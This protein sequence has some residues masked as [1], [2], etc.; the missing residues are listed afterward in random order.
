MSL[1]GFSNHTFSQFKFNKQRTNNC[2]TKYYIT[3]TTMRFIQP[4]LLLILFIVVLQQLTFVYTEDDTVTA[5]STSRPSYP[6]FPR[7]F[8]FGAGSS[9]VQVEGASTEDGKG[10]S[11]WDTFAKQAGRIADG[12]TLDVAADFYHKYEDDIRLMKNMGLKAYR[13]SLSWSRI[14]PN[15]TRSA[16]SVNHKAINHYIRIFRKLIDAGIEPYV[17]LYHWDLPQPLQDSFGGWLDKERISAAFADYADVCFFFFGRYVKNWMTINEPWATALVA[18][19]YGLY[20]PG[21]FSTTNYYT[22]S[23]NQLI[24]HAAAVKVYR[25][26]YFHQRGEIGIVF[27]SDWYEPLHADNAA[28]AAAAERYQL[29]NLGLY[30][31]PLYFGD[32]PQIVRDY[33]GS[34][35]P[36]FTAA[37]KELIRGSND[38]FAINHYTSRYV[39]AITS[40]PSECSPD[41]K[42]NADVQIAYCNG[43]NGTRI[44][45]QT[46]TVYNSVYPLG[47]R[48]LVKWISN[49]YGRNVDILIAEN[50]VDV[51]SESTLPLAQQLQDDFRVD[52]LKGYLAELANAINIDRI[53]VKGYLL[54]SFTDSW[55][56]IA[57]FVTKYGIHHVDFSSSAKTRTA[58][59]SANWYAGLIQSCQ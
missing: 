9:A 11:I 57:G 1:L 47:L 51:P 10:V 52:Y 8:I 46:N 54:W 4:L 49:R 34:K 22:V 28:D 17:T 36:N 19:G 3:H 23:H 32:Y 15:G 45:A 58:K 48:K 33:V 44:G 20:A 25:D 6:S 29:L 13:M 5:A 30:A 41:F 14:L 59:K 56:W 43:R 26:R 53:R 38:F 16:G 2:T 7:N 39:G 18:Y 31:D 40:S 42:T 55:E 50:G 27:N 37:E 12:S 24:A 35:L 21:I